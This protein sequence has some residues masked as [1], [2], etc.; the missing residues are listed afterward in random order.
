MEQV[1]SI[2][3]SRKEGLSLGKRGMRTGSLVQGKDN[4]PRRSSTCRIWQ[5]WK[6]RRAHKT[7]GKERGG[8]EKRKRESRVGKLGDKN[9]ARE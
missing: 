9:M 5:E 2:E 4:N 1:L 8:E 7:T 6:R 3:E